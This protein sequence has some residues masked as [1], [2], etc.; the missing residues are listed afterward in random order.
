MATTAVPTI[1]YDTTQPTE[2]LANLITALGINVIMAGVKLALGVITGSA[3]MT[4]EGLHSFADC[5]S[6]VVLIVGDKHSV[7][8]SKARYF[9][10]LIAAINIFLV[11]GMWAVREAFDVFAGKPIADT[12]TLLSA[13]VYLFGIVMETTSLRVTIRTMNTERNGRSWWTYLRETNNLALVTVFMEDAADITGGV[14]GLASIG[15]RV[16]TGSAIWD[17]VAAAMVGA[18]LISVAIELGRRNITL[19]AA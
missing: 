2:T 15:L 17:G 9:W 3:A 18:I 12:W 6:E 19:L 13:C 14:L 5:A 11:G 10:A 1:D 16:L 4:S 7:Y 8:W